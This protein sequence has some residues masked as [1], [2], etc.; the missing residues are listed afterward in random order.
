MIMFRVALLSALLLTAS[1]PAALAGE[2]I[3]KAGECGVASGTLSLKRTSKTNSFGNPVWKLTLPDCQTFEAVSGRGTTQD[4]D[5]HTANNESPLPQGK[6]SVETVHRGPWGNPE[7]GD[8]FIDIFPLFETGRTELGI[9]HDPSFDKN[10]TDDGTA[11][12]IGLVNND[13]LK[14]L[15][16]ALDSQNIRSLIVEN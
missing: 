13:D 8:T 14:K 10:K 12:C 3:S 16:K 15:V 11:G 9:H 6:Y 7:L 1:S 4:L 5:R 2:G